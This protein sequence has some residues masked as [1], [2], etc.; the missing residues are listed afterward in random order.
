M[1]LVLLTAY[2]KKST[3]FLCTL[4]KKK[5]TY[6]VWFVFPDG[7][8]EPSVSVL[9]MG[10]HGGVEWPCLANKTGAVEWQGYVVRLG[11]LVFVEQTLVQTLADTAVG[12]VGTD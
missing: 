1:H 10:E 11:Q 5:S 9:E 8:L 6:S 7:G 3:C 2:I 4:L 12:A